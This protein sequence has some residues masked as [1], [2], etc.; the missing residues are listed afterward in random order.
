MTR[1]RRAHRY[2]GA[3]TLT[4]MAVAASTTGTANAATLPVATPVK[5]G[6]SIRV[7]P[8]AVQFVGNQVVSA[9]IAQ[10]GFNTMLTAANPLATGTALLTNYTA[11]GSNWKAVSG[12]AKVTVDPANNGTLVITGQLNTITANVNAKT[13]GLLNL[14]VNGTAAVTSATFSGTAKIGPGVNGSVATVT[15]PT[16]SLTANNV[17]VTMPT[18]PALFVNP[19]VTALKP[20][21]ETT[22]AANLKQAL[23]TQVTSFVNAFPSTLKIPIYGGTVRPSASIVSASGSGGGLN[24]VSDASLV[25]VTANGPKN[26]TYNSVGTGPAPAATSV[27]PNGTRYPLGMVV[28]KDLIN[29]AAA[30][31]AQAGV[32][33]TTLTKKDIPALGTVP[34]L[35]NALGLG[36]LQIS[37]V[38]LR[39]SVAAA[40]T[41]S[42]SSAPGTM[43]TLGLN[44][45]NVIVDLKMSGSAVFQPLVSIA[46]NASA[47]FDLVPVNGT[48]LRPHLTGMPR[49]TITSFKD[50]STTDSQL[51]DAA[52]VQA[53][54]D[55]LPAEFLPFIDALIPAVAIPKVGPYT[56]TVGAVWVTNPSANFL[57]I[58]GNLS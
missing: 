6:A 31:A 42:L 47:P 27:A 54:W 35:L 55:S 37:D 52:L 57:S 29:Q 38:Q 18:L 24:I 45:L 34:A 30:A 2:V 41:V 40:P 4:A 36:S 33:N 32:L 1:L 12:S 49:V 25:P 46:V 13:V 23:A 15:V 58:A 22:L 28:S 7:E 17:A 21:I 51:I 16:F 9:L 5:S 44:S 56:L 14:N 19:I 39:T 43:G 10:P 3:L 20:K 48:A 11:T 8:A 26:L 50:L 53:I